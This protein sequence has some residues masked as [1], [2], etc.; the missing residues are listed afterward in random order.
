MSSIYM[1]DVRRN[2]NIFMIW[3]LI[4]LEV[5][6]PSAEWTTVQPS[7]IFTTFLNVRL[8]RTSFTVALFR[9]MA[10]S[11]KA[12]HFI[13][14]VFMVPDSLSF[15]NANICWA[16]IHLPERSHEFFFWFRPNENIPTYYDYSNSTEVYSMHGIC[17]W[18]RSQMMIT[19]IVQ[20]FQIPKI[21]TACTMY[22]V[23]WR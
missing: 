21:W 19:T 23:E 10:Y 4:V 2:A 3:H 7:L 1:L 16:N 17:I 14:Y 13:Y 11:I 20:S 8:K 12:I 22:H 6:T 5:L 18:H 9:R 15:G